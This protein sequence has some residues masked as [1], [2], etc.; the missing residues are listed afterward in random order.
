M[1][2]SRSVFGDSRMM[3]HL[4]ASFTVVISDHHLRL[5]YILYYRPLAILVHVVAL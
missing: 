5:S 3:L 2:N 1:G 4:V